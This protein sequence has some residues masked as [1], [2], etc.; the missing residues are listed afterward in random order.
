MSDVLVLITRTISTDALGNETAQESE[1]T[2]FCEVDSIS[3]SEFF[4]AAD[5]ELNPQF[6]FTVFF[7]DYNGE[8]TVKYGGQRYSVY[9]T[10]RT[11]DDLEIYVER[12]VGA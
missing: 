5:T 12:K 4:A 1:K 3:H 10:Y 9:R 2:V 11:G 6:R 8:E 7:G